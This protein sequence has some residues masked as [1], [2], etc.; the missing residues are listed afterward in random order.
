M[1]AVGPSRRKKDYAQSRPQ[2]DLAA[3]MSG[4]KLCGSVFCSSSRNK[5]GGHCAVLKENKAI[6]VTET[7]HYVNSYYP[8]SAFRTRQLSAAEVYQFSHVSKLEQL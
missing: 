1:I 2:T 3:V 7:S 6:T 5:R 4:N 8:F